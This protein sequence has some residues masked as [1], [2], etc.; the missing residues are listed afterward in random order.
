MLRDYWLSGV[1]TAWPFTSSVSNPSPL[2]LRKGLGVLVELRTSGME[3]PHPRSRLL[4]R[5]MGRSSRFPH[6]AQQSPH[7][8]PR[9]L[10]GWYRCSALVS[11]KCHSNIADARDSLASLQ[12]LWAVSSVALYV[13]W[14]GGVGPWISV[15]LWLWLGVL[16][17][18]Q[19][20][21]LGIIL[22]QTLSRLH[23]GLLPDVG[24]RRRHCGQDNHPSTTYVPQLRPS[25]P[26]SS[27]YHS[28]SRWRVR[29]SSLSVTSDIAERSSLVRDIVCT[30]WPC[31]VL[32]APC[33][34]D[35][36]RRTQN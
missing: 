4:H 33:D 16:D 18:I 8:V 13:P 30:V 21:G 32:S 1:S 34:R 27:R 36:T 5:C 20:V 26:C 24:R 3:S 11:G 7:V 29:S 10:R 15:S 19:G 31:S 28:R 9:N 17:A 12:M 14:A 35:S 22:L 23:P 6:M 2:V 25:T